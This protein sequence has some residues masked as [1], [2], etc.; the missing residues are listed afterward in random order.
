MAEPVTHLRA[1][2]KTGV[3]ACG[4]QADELVLGDSVVGI[5][6]QRCRGT[7]YFKRVVAQEVGGLLAGS[8]QPAYVAADEFDLT[9][10]Q[11]N[12]IMSDA[13][14]E[15][16]ETCGWWC[17]EDEIDVVDDEYVCADCRQDEE[18]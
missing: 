7:G 6:C 3:S 17:G 2:G 11:V 13:G 14:Y 18:D 12:Q 4:R 15:L 1:E 8:C 5:E 10:D 16:C 9:E